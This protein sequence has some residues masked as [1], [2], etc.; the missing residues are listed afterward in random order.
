MYINNSTDAN[1]IEYYGLNKGED[2]PDVIAKL[3]DAGWSSKNWFIDTDTKSGSNI[4]ILTDDY[5]NGLFVVTPSTHCLWPIW[6]TFIDGSNGKLN[7]D[8]NLGQ[9]N[10]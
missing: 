10:N 8:G 9:L 1:S 2:A 7:N 4:L 6:Q 3:K 5:I